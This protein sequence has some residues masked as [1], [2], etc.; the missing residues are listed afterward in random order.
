[1]VNNHVFN[2]INSG[3]LYIQGR[4]RHY[5]PI[6][7]L[8]PSVI[9]KMNPLPTN[10][11]LIAAT[12]MIMSYGNSHMCQDGSVENFLLIVNMIEQNI[13]NIPYKLM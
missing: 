3:M 13:F 6:L 12:C 10:D 8:R 9:F 2:L 7:V 1:M 4:D 5:R 11:D